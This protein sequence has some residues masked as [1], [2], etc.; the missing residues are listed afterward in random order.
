M[1]CPLVLGAKETHFNSGPQKVRLVELYTSQ[2]CSSCPPAQHWLNQLKQ[3]PKLWKKFI[4]L[5]FHVNYWNHLSWKDPFSHQKYSKRQ[6]QYNRVIQKGVFTPQILI[7][8]RDYKKWRSLVPV[9]SSD[10]RPGELTGE[11]KVKLSNKTQNASFSFKAQDD[12][13]ELTCFAATIKL[14]H[15]TDVSSGENSG[16]KLKE[17]FNVTSLK[18]TKAHKNKRH[19]TCKIPVNILDQTSNSALAFW[20]AHSKNLKVIQATGGVLP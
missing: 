19:H 17:N 10:A 4:P 18:Q 20:V 12:Y 8:G 3:S 11:L 1:A 13:E 6:R 7:D 5:S 9:P 16:K 2:S 15:T 14:V